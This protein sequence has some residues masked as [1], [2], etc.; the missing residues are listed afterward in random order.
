MP[1]PARLYVASS[2][3][4]SHEAHPALP[5]RVV[6]A[7]DHRAVRRSLRLLL[8][9]AEDVEVVAEADDL[10]SALRHVRGHR[11][12]V[13]VID[14]GLPNGGS[15]ET[16]SRLRERAPET[17]IVVLTMQDSPVFAEKVLGAGARG[18]VLKEHADTELVDAVLAAGRGEQYVTPRVSAGLQALRRG[19]SGDGLSEREVEV[20]RLIALGHTSA[21]I[22]AM[23][24]LSRRTV[25]SHRAHI[26]RKLGVRTRADLVSYALG[27]HLIGS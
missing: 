27:R 24:H 15:V 9:V 20:L 22:A 26:H 3:S 21:E 16:I 11:P 23:L 5:V 8:D 13:L 25:E 18:L 6:L 2:D 1:S 19:L 12:H 10:P 7:D 17:E 14:L 4:D